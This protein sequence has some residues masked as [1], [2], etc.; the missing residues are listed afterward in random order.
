MKIIEVMFDDYGVYDDTAM[1]VVENA[2]VEETVSKLKEADKEGCFKITVRDPDTL[3]SAVN[4]I[5]AVYDYE[6][7]DDEQ[8]G[9]C[10]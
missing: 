7:G 9:S 4:A 10:K 6:E 1:L 5:A 3:E 8:D 2:A